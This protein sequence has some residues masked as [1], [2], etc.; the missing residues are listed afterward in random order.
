MFVLVF[1]FALL[2]YSHTAVQVTKD[3]LLMPSEAL[4]Q[5]YYK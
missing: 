4:C 2:T 3:K 5:D 1:V